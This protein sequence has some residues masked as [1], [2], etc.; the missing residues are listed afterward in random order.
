MLYSNAVV[1]QKRTSSMGK[2]YRRSNDDYGY[3]FSR[4]KSLREKRQQ[5]NKVRK[6]WGSVNDYNSPREYDNR[7]QLPAED[8]E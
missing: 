5:G 6:D 3:G 1:N 2:T 8:R 4:P 7:K